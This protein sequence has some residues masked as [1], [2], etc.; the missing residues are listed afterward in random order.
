MMITAIE[1]SFIMVRT[2]EDE[3]Q[4]DILCRDLSIYGTKSKCASIDVMTSDDTFFDTTQ[5]KKP[6]FA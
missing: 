5:K 6:M 3:R 1:A 2:E 4:K